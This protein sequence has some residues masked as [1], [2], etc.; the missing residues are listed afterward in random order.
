MGFLGV[1]AYFGEELKLYLVVGCFKFRLRLD[2]PKKPEKAKKAKAVSAVAPADAPAPVSAEKPV[3]RAKSSVDFKALV[4]LLPMAVR[5]LGR[6]LKFNVIRLKVVAASAEAD[7]AALMYGRTWTAIGVVTPFLKRYL[8]IK[9][10]DVG[11]ELDF[12]KTKP[13]ISGRVK[14][15]VSV[16]LAIGFAIW[17]GLKIL[18]ILKK[19]GKNNGIQTESD[20]K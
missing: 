9:R 10:Y 2:K 13:A 17:A 7:R 3:E 4:P 6:I 16:F 14:L 19:G 11:A 1:D 15:T 5:K 20:D 18:P 12:A 8:R